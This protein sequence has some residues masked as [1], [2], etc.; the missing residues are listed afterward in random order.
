MLE[1]FA[2]YWV[3]V[4][5]LRVNGTSLLPL[6]LPPPTEPCTASEGDGP[7]AAVACASRAVAN[8]T[9]AAA[10]GGD[11]LLGKAM[12]DT[13]NSAACLP[14]GVFDA[15]R[16]RLE[17]AAR[18]VPAI[19]DGAGGRTVFDGYGR[20]WVFSL[21]FFLCVDGWNGDGGTRDCGW[22]GGGRW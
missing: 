20:R 6:A 17:E 18:N 12:V 4:R 13:G 21:S 7:A 16:K 15:L 9:V 8:G 1:P 22:V 5:D 14:E 10:A 11:A 19:A 2:H 3:G